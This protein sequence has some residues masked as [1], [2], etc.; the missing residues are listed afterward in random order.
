MAEEQDE[1]KPPKKGGKLKLIIGALVLL[2]AGAGG[3]Y[4]L[5]V[6]GFVGGAAAEEGPDVPRLVRKGDEDPYA[7]GDGGKNAPP[8]VVHGEGGSEYRTAYHRFDDS[9]TSNLSDSAGLI[10][11]ELAAATMHDG[12]VLQWLEQHELAVRSAIL[13]ELAATSED[14]VYSSEGRAELQQRLTEAVNATLEQKEG[15][16]GVDNIYFEG[17]LIQ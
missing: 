5:F 15:F 13:V 1:E 16:G 14:A 7:V 12:R 10:Q 2:A 6:G 11:V 3:A 8:P 17:F 4:G 9:F